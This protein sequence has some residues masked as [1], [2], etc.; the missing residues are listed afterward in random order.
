MNVMFVL[1]LEKEIIFIY[2][3]IN[4]EQLLL[5]SFVRIDDCVFFMVHPFTFSDVVHV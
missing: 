2:M 5:L 3:E 1:I 4:L